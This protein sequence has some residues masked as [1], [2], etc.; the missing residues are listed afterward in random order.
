MPGIPYP[1][2][3][4]VVPGEHIVVSVIRQ[5]SWPQLWLPLYQLY[6]LTDDEIAIIEET[7]EV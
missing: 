6:G 3:S 5:L 7:T 2:F 1:V 4:T